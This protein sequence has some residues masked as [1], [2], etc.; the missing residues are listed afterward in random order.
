MIFY[1]YCQ[2]VYGLVGYRCSAPDNKFCWWLWDS[3]N[4]N[5]IMQQTTGLLT[6]AKQSM[7]IF[8]QCDLFIA[9]V[10]QCRCLHCTI[11]STILLFN[12]SIPLHNQIPLIQMCYRLCGVHTLT[13]VVLRLSRSQSC[14]TK[15]HTY[16][17]TYVI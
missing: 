2:N 8:Y 5:C 4:R 7:R 13:Y 14:Y 12:S 10:I 17:R 15:S 1:K 11:E 16:L 3:Y 6:N 9:S